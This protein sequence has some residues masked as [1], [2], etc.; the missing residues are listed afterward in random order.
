MGEEPV[1]PCRSG[2]RREP[3]VTDDE[4]P[5]ERGEDRD[6]RGVETAFGI[7]T[8]HRYATD[9]FRRLEAF[10]TDVRAGALPSYAFL[11]PQYLDAPG[12][13]ASDQHPPHD[14]GEGER[15]IA[16]VYDTLRSNEAIWRKCLLVLLYDEHGGFYDHVPPPAAA[17][18]DGASAGNVTFR[19]DR[20][21]VRVPA[22]LV[23]PW[24]GKGRV[25]HRIY[26][27]TSL[28]AT[29]RTLFDLREPLTRRDARAN[30]FDDLN[31]LEAIRPA[32][33]APSNLSALVP[34]RPARVPGLTRK[35]SDLERSLLALG[36]ALRHPG[37]IGTAA[38]VPGPAQG[39]T[40]AP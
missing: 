35:L 25:D 36:A 16:W 31:F 21:G 8:L 1:R 14:L 22:L 10:A 33:D 5:R 24:V 20:L 30:A 37:G 3:P 32:G 2:G 29:L 13:P 39:E 6:Q 38:P 11:E 18:P 12:R 9:G 7:S 34:D 40:Q 15:L 19:F 26:D 28:L 17:P 23:S 27:H 4:A